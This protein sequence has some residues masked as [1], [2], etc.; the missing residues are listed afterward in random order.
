METNHDPSHWC[1]GCGYEFLSQAPAEDIRCPECGERWLGA[2]AREASRTRH[3]VTAFVSAIVFL[4]VA[5]P[6][7]AIGL[8]MMG[9]VPFSGLSTNTSPWLWI[10]MPLLPLALAV[11]A[12][13][14]ACRLWP[15]PRAGGW[16][17]PRSS[18]S[19]S[20]SDSVL[21][22]TIVL[23]SLLNTGWV[24]VLGWLLVMMGALA[25]AGP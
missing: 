6:I 20:T 16:P 23:A 14:M 8:F 17:C 3:P 24:L 2:Q 13:S 25:T 22:V 12:V 5:P 4:I 1:P 15:P 11:Y 10:L 9:M 18:R 7:L 19:A 21:K